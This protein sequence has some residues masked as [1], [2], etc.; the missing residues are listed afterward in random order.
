MK[1]IL[2]LLAISYWL[3]AI[4]RPAD[5]AGEFATNYN[6]RYQ[7]N[8]DGVV[9][10]NQDI[11]LTNKLSAVYAT[12]Y[13][14]TLPSTKIQKI[15]A[16]DKVGLCQTE[17]IQNDKA[18]TIIINFNEQVVGAGKTLNFNLNYES[19]DIAR[20]NGEV[21][22]INIPK[23]ANESDIDNYSITLAVPQSFGQPAFIRPEP[24][25]NLIEG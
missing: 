20:K 8:Q 16:S 13:S 17:I 3:L 12:K 19:L 6:L 21:W 4:P 18:T 24:V 22:E 23:I 11:S 5:A 10:V 15:K 2:W 9:Y 1:R 25:E 7:V 14:L